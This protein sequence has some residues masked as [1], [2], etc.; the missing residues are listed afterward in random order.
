MEIHGA[1]SKAVVFADWDHSPHLSAAQKDAL[2]GSIPPWQRDSR[3]RGVPQ[4]G[5]GAIF[6]IGESEL[7]VE[8]FE[9]PEH[10]PRVYALDVGWARTAAIW[11]AIDRESETV[12]LYSE[13]YRGQAEPSI[14]ATAI[15]SRGDWLQGVIDPAARGRAQADGRQLISDY[16]DLGLNLIEADHAVESG[17]Y[18]MWE[19]F[20]AG[21]LKV[22]KTLQNWLMEYRIYR[23]DEK[24]RIVKSNDHLMDATRYLVVSGLSLATTKPAPYVETHAPMSDFA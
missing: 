12:Y 23:R 2:L 1:M 16:R 10:W 5:S 20:S 8:N 11:G 7:V 4:L 6:P 17:L 19:R 24:G 3:T 18:S 15:R 22:F 21:K 14:H 9:I 13:Y